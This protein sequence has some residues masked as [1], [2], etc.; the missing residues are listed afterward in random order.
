MTHFQQ[1]VSRS[2]SA[3]FT[4]AFGIL[5]SAFCVYLLATS[6]VGAL[7]LLL[8]V[9]G[10]SCA[11]YSIYFW[12]HPV[13]WTVELSEETLRWQSPHM[14]RVTRELPLSDIVSAW[15]SPTETETVELHL[16]SGERVSLPPACV[17]RPRELVAALIAANPNIRS[18]FQ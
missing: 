15:A 3:L 4:A 17:P 5:F 8:A 14:P 13:A 10:A 2:S 9:L 6:S 12:L 18:Q 1:H 16:A 7:G 11:A